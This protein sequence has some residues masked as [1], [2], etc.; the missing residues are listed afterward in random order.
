VKSSDHE[1]RRYHTPK[2]DA[3]ARA[4]RERIRATAETL[5][6]RDGYARTSMGAIAKGAAVAEKT[7][8]LAFPTKADLLNEIIVTALRADDAPKPFRTRLSEALA[9][10]PEQLLAEFAALTADLM[11]RTGRIMALGESAAS[12]DPQLAAL[13]DRG[14][15]AM[16]SDCHDVAAALAAR[17]ALAA[18]VSADDAA[19]TIYAIANDSVYLRLVDGC[20]WSPDRYRAW[21]EQTLRKTLLE[22]RPRPRSPGRSP[23]EQETRI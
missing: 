10:E 16:R 23:P 5:F 9:A 13:R 17:G 6:L 19:S 3:R 1:K 11:A 7:V 14:H 22:S 4:T 21:L 2:R 18:D 8:Y 15:A 20:G 12:S